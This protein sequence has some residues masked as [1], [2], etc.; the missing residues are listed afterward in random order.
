MARTDS[1]SSKLI[2]SNVD[3]AD[4]EYIVGTTT[5]GSDSLSEVLSGA[6]QRGATS[7]EIAALEKDWTDRHEMCTFHEGEDALSAF[8]C[9]K[10]NTMLQPSKK[11]FKHP[12]LRT[13]RVLMLPTCLPPM[14]N[15]TVTP[16]V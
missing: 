7:G 16:A 2:S 15:P 13:K 3:V 4:H 10:L 6:E 1:E 11:P 9:L 12:R 14:E 5:P 8:S